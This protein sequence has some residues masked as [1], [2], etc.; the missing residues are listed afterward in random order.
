MINGKSLSFEITVNYF[1]Q[2]LSCVA[3]FIG[4]VCID[5]MCTDMVFQHDGQ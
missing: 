3:F 1:N 4:M 2:L 5:Q